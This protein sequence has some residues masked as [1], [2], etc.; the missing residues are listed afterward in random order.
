MDNTVSENNNGLDR[1]LSPLGIWAISIGTA[2]GWGS[3]VMPGTTFIPIAG[4]VGTALGMVIGGFVMLLI[5]IN[6][7]YLMNLYH[8][9]AL[10]EPFAKWIH[11]LLPFLSL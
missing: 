2:I 4:P 10:F 1:Y 8:W 6:Y 11:P 9:N 7:H 3:F 5:G